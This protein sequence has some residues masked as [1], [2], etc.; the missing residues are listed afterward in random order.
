MVN[1]LNVTKVTQSKL[2]S[3]IALSEQCLD[4][5]QRWSDDLSC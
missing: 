1:K 2:V 5:T 4:D 3:L